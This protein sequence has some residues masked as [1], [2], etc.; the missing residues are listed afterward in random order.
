MNK[1]NL[2]SSHNNKNTNISTNGSFICGATSN[3]ILFI[4]GKHI[5]IYNVSTRKQSI[6]L[7][8]TED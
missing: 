2:G 3:L 8:N 4:A 6:I 7:K 1:D 5:V